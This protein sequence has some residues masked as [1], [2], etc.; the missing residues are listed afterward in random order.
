[1]GIQLVYTICKNADKGNSETESVLTKLEGST[2]Y[3]QVSVTKGAVCN[4]SYS[5]DGKKFIK[6]GVPFTAEP[7]K[8]IGAKA[9]LF[10]TRTEQTNDS[11]YAD[12]DWFRVEAL[13]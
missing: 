3:F 4:F 10:C 2:V 12:V 7:G 5:M 6:A 1:D 13:K 11:G 8:W 9:G